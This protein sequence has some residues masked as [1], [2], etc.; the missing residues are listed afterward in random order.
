MKS[1][2]YFLLATC[3]GL[4]FGVSNAQETYVTGTAKVKVEPNT[5]FYFGDNL[6]V[7]STTN[8]VLENAGNIKVEGDYVNASATG[9]NFVNT[10]DVPSNNTS[11]GQVI[12][13][14]NSDAGRLTMEKGII[15]PSVFN[16]GQFAI[17]F[18]FA[19]VDEAM[20]NLFGT[21]YST[22]NSRYYKSMMVWDNIDKPEFDHF[23]AG[24]GLGTNSPTAYY[25]LNLEYNSANIKPIME[26]NVKLAYKGVP[27]NEAFP[28]IP[29]NTNMYHFDNAGWS[30]WK[31]LK[32]NYNEKYSTYIDD[33]VRMVS[34]DAGYGRNYFQF[35]N[36]YTSNIDLAYIGSPATPGYDDGNDISG[37]LAVARVADLN[38]TAQG[39]SASSG[40]IVA[41]YNESTN[42]WAGDP[43]ALLVKPFEP[44]IIVLNNAATNT[45]NRVINFSDKLKTFSMTPNSL[46]GG[47][48]TP[49]N[50][51][52]EGGNIDVSE[53]GFGFIATSSAIPRFYQ[54]G[55]SL[56][57]SNGAP[58][59]NKA[60]VVVTN[61]GVVNGVPN[62]LESEYSDFGSRTGFYLVQEG[63]STDAIPTRK[64]HINT[65]NTGYIN[66]P[67]PMFFNRKAG[68]LQGYYIKADLFYKDIFTQLTEENNYVDGN[69]FFFYDRT[70]DVLMPITTDFNYYVNVSEKALENRYTVYWNGGPV[71]N[72][73]EMNET[74]IAGS[75]VVY[76]DQQT[77]KIRFNDQWD[78]AN[79]KVY[80]MS[81]KSIMSFENVNTHNDFELKLPTSGIYVVKA[82]S[83]TGEVYTQKI[84][85]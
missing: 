51:D 45:G 85:K 66:K 77:H 71:F 24:D 79:I 72:K 69:S 63:E 47:V 15:N 59:G 54:L 50:E 58:T 19:N 35:G 16:W 60:Y 7:T 5:L 38:Y 56:Y 73:G 6:H 11:Y 20:T 75:T 65:V 67:I 70:E 44:F 46:G 36:P 18:H 84:I 10:W 25:I 28:N 49:K 64:M 78:S 57:H 14:E 74:L 83:N 22:S 62:A 3:M 48:V 39:G 27:S 61:A 33:K 55:L 29:M 2:N 21:T 80:D 43:S 17:P 68:D 13:N 82:E 12:I 8:A 34:D 81:G 32:N 41:T 9:A 37:L 53:D 26:S 30:S 4:A 52:F 42:V 31:N 1:I 40:M 76:K 23:N